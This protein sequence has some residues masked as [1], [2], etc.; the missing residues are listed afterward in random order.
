MREQS[1]IMQTVARWLAERGIPARS[2]WDGAPCERLNGV[3]VVVSMK[4]YAA[5][6]GGFE[7]YLGERY[8]DGRG[9]WEEVYGKRV[10]LEL[11][12]DLYAPENCTEQ[13]TQRVLESMVSALTLEPPDGLRVGEILCGEVGREEALC[14]LKREVTAK[15]TAWLQ[16]TCEDGGEF[17]DFELRGGWK[18]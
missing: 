10:E 18:I 17:L 5:H 2:A 9:A 4:K 15:C 8:D 11:G 12:L 14:C 7:N 1:G 6:P 13:E 3:C 16:A